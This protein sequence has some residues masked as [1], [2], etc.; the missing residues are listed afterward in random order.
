MA[1]VPIVTEVT[2]AQL[3]ALVA[4]TGLNEGLQYKVTDKDWLLIA[5]STNTLKAAT[6]LLV[7]Q[8]EVFPTYISSDVLL[9]ETGIITSD[10]SAVPHEILIPIGYLYTK[11]LGETG[12]D[13][14]NLHI[15]DSDG[16]WN[17]FRAPVLLAGNKW[18][19][20]LES[21]QDDLGS[22]N[23]NSSMVIKTG[24]LFMTATGNIAPGFKIV[25]KYEQS[26]F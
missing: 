17:V 18:I 4:A 22:L 26:Y 12:V 21:I 14:T 8:N 13:L 15:M 24:S 2:K 23:V 6:G 20:N 7:I 1:T 25:I 3:D 9:C 11:L 19:S 5:T 16:E 10:I